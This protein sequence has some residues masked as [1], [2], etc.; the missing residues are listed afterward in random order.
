MRP[1]RHLLLAQV[2]FVWNTY[3]DMDP[4]VSEWT[5]AVKKREDT[6]F[7]GGLG[8]KSRS[9]HG[10]MHVIEKEKRSFCTLSVH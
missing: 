1:S 4:A 5:K 3:T 10:K 8:I 7:L 6:M 2:F 9:A